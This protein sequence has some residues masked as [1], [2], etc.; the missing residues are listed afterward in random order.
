VDIRVMDYREL[1]GEPFDAVASIGMVEH[2]GSSQIDVYARQVA[3]LVKPGGR[4]L[5]HGI[6]RLR[7][8]DPEAGPFSER[9]VFPDAAPLHLS[10]IQ[11]AIEGAGLETHH[12][13]GFREDY[14]E[15]LRHWMRRLED[16]IDEAER[17]V[18]AER[19]RVWRV[20]VRAARRGF[21]TGFTSVYQVRCSKPR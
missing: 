6:A 10:R 2:V 13:E 21:E 18:G 19:I 20:Y 15:T 12:V 9:Y 7:V 5:N 16:R 14:A 4:V 1:T 11:A 3:R 17:L 8:G